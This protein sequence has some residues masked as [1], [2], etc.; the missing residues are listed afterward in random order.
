VSPLSSIKYFFFFMDAS[1]PKTKDS[2][3]LRA[4]RRRLPLRGAEN[5]SLPRK[6]QTKDDIYCLPARILMRLIIEISL[7]APTNL[8]SGTKCTQLSRGTLFWARKTRLYANKTTP[9]AHTHRSNL[10]TGEIFCLD[11]YGHQSSS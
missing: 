7:C 4:R 6:R 11:K 5:K 1:T 8:E 9:T 10:F 2:L 3:L